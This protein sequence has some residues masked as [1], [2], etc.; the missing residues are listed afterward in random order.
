MINKNKKFEIT[1]TRSHNY[2]ILIIGASYFASVIRNPPILSLVNQSLDI[3]ERLEK[4]HIEN[5]E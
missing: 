5:G 4:I 1:I 2:E 3:I